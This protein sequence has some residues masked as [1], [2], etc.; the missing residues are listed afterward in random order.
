MSAG[1]ARP[2]LRFQVRRKQWPMT[3]R[4]V[5]PMPRPQ[6]MVRTR[7]DVALEEFLARKAYAAATRRLPGQVATALRGFLRT[8]GKWLRPLLHMAGL[9][10]DQLAAVLPTIDA[11]RIEVMYGQCLDLIATGRPTDD[12]RGEGPVPGR[13]HNRIRH[14]RRHAAGRMD[15]RHHPRLRIVER[16]LQEALTASIDQSTAPKDRPRNTQTAKEGLWR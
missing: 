4:S 7:I 12:R 13:D 8:G 3:T 16:V 9:A 1:T 14:R 10:A 11:V 15:W 6:D 5:D 2:G